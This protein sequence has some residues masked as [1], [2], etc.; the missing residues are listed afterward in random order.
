MVSK[1][2]LQM[3]LLPATDVMIFKNIFAEFFSKKNWRF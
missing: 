2:Q 1:Y 3:Q